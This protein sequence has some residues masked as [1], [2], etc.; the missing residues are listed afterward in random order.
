M[1]NDAYFPNY[2]QNE[3]W[4]VFI[5]LAPFVGGLIAVTGAMFQAGARKGGTH[6]SGDITGG[7]FQGGSE[8]AGTHQAGSITGTLFQGG[9]RKGDMKGT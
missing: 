3:Y 7:T 9:S 8:K 6:Q 5:Q 4:P 1:F 2:F